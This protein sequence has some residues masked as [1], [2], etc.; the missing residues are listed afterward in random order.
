LATTGVLP[1][2]T[3]QWLLRL[4]PAAA[5][6]VQQSAPAYPQV[7]AGYSTMDGYFPL[8]GWAGFGV[9]CGYTAL[10]LALAFHLLRRR[11]A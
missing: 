6:A 3:G 10:T 5:F 2:N 9:L 7:A 1:A 8:P 4:T 11:D